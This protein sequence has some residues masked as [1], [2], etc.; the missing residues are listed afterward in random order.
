MLDDVEPQELAIL[1][2]HAFGQARRNAFRNPFQVIRKRSLCTSTLLAAWTA[3][4]GRRIGAGIV[5][6]SFLLRRIGLHHNGITI[7]KIQ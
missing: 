7:A 2:S 4:L 6:I 3:W 5:G 1:Q